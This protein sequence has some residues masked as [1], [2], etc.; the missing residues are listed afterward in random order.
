MKDEPAQAMRMDKGSSP[1]GEK[2]APK[3]GFINLL[4]LLVRMEE[5]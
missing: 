4:E 3:T 5:R 2:T 1:G